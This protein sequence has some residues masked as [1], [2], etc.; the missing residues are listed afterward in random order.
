MFAEIGPHIIVMFL[1]VCKLQYLLS[2]HSVFSPEM[3]KSLNQNEPR[4]SNTKINFYFLL[5]I[6]FYDKLFSSDS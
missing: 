5:K 2:F 6:D 4:E 3:L 1:F